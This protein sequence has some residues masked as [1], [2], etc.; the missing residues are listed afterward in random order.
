[1]ID[2][3]RLGTDERPQQTLLVLYDGDCGICTRTAMVLRR[4]DR[5]RRLR[6]VAAQASADVVDRPAPDVLLSAIHVR[7]IDGRWYVGGKAAIEIAASIPVLRPIAVLSRL[8]LVARAIDRGY[9]RIA[10]NRTRLSKLLGETSC[11]VDDR[12][13]P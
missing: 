6:L 4:L 2:R 10:A 1:M 9:G 5:G 13:G 11:A 12:A 3:A 8:P 7:D